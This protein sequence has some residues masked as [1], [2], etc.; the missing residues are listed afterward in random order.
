MKKKAKSNQDVAGV[1]VQIQEQLAV[2]NEKLDAFMTKS[3]TELA[4]A[5]AASKPAVRITPSAPQT[6][7]PVRPTQ[8]KF[9]NQRQM[10]AVVCYECGK[11]AELPFKPSGDRPVFCPEC[12]A[13]RKGRTPPAP[14]VPGKL[15]SPSMSSPGLQSA[16]PSVT[17]A[18]KAKKKAAPAKKTKTKRAPA[19]KA[20]VKKKAAVK[21]KTSRKK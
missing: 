11:D 15:S 20:P 18:L 19:K 4:Q 6:Q 12:F 8:H 3:L 5:L 17:P 10:Y 13:A 16:A 2:M 9:L 1:M 14:V 21:K 7:G